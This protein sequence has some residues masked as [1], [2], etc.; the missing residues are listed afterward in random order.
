MQKLFVF[1]FDGTVVNSWPFFA[2][3]VQEYSQEFNLPKPCLDTCTYTKANS[4]EM[5]KAE[6]MLR[7]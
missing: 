2:E 6:G 4:N 7:G 5:L 1:D 3:M